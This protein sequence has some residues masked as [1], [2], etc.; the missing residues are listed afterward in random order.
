[1]SGTLCVTENGMGYVRG[2]LSTSHFSLSKIIKAQVEILRI[3]PFFYIPFSI[4]VFALSTY[5]YTPSGRRTKIS[6]PN[7]LDLSVPLSLL[8]F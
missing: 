6:T 4:S 5:S 7:S 3:S 2:G 8:G 1:M